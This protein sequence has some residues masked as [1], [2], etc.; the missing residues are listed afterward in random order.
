MRR[1]RNNLLRF[2]TLAMC[3]LAVVGCDESN[4]DKMEKAM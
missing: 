4:G 1:F 2:A 3:A